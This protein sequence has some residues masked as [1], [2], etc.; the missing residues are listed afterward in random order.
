MTEAGQQSPG[1]EA[2]AAYFAHDTDRA[3]EWR[4]LSA[5]TKAEHV[6]QLLARNGE[7][8][9]TVL[10][11]GCGDGALLS[12]LARRGVGRRHTGVEVSEPA[13]QLALGQPGITDVLTYDGHHLPFEDHSHEL[14]ICSHVLEHTDD[15]AAVTRELVRVSGD[16]LLIEVPLEDNLS[17]RRPAARTLSKRAG[18]VQQFT[19][20]AIRD[21]LPG[22]VQ[23]LGE[24]VDPLP[25]QASTFWAGRWRG[26]AKWATRRLLHAAGLSERLITVHYALLARV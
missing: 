25:R 12:E 15:P 19:R 23:I 7:N 10:E 13:R 9:G 5:L 4:R 8:P 20:A 22:N 21:L 3:I 1:R 2:A 16:L 24:L 26:T 18:H 6:A 11:V 14:V 17:A